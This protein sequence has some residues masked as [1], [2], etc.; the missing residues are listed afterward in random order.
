MM[1]ESF[2]E[3]STN[4]DTLSSCDIKSQLSSQASLLRIKH[5]S[6]QRCYSPQIY[7]SNHNHMERR[8]FLPEI[9]PIGRLSTQRPNNDCM[10]NERYNPNSRPTSRSLSSVYT[11]RNSLN[12]GQ[13][14][15][16]NLDCAIS[17]EEDDDT[18]TSSPHPPAS[19][20]KSN[21]AGRNKTRYP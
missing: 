19:T 12:N 18:P 13:D 4:R 21:S 1:L 16:S 5:A 15:S 9:D 2:S 17:Q 6:P 8:P 20:R 3:E 10:N 11:V 7:Q 14:L